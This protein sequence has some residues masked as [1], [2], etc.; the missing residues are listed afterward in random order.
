[1]VYVEDGHT[2]VILST[3]EAPLGNRVV[4]QCAEYYV[5]VANLRKDSV[6]VKVGESINFR[7]QIGQTG[8]SGDPPVPHVR[9]FTTRRSW[10]ENGIP[11]PQLFDIGFRFHVRND[12]TLPDY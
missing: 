9:V 3:P 6:I 10:D 11:V 2:D 5:T 8:S 7:V 12:L 1:V 4:L